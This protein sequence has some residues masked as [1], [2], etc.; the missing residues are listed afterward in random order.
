MYGHETDRDTFFHTSIGQTG[1]PNK[2][3][4]DD[5]ADGSVDEDELDGLDND[6]DWI[7][8]VDDL[9]GDGLTDTMETG[10]LGSYDPVTN[11]DPA[12]D[13]FDPSTRDLCRT[14]H[15]LKDSREVYA[16]NN[17]RPDIGEPH[18]DEDYG[19]LSESDVYIA[20]N[21]TVRT[22]LITDHIPLGIKVWQKSYTWRSLIKQP[23]MPFEYQIVNVG[24]RYLDSV[25]VGFFADPLVGPSTASGL[26]SNKYAGYLPELR[27]AFAQNA[28][29]RPSTP[30]GVVVL[31]TP[32]PLDSLRYTFQWSDFSEN[33]GTD[34][35]HY[36]YMSSGVIKPD[37]PRSQPGDVQFLLSFGP[38]RTIAPGET[39]RITVAL[40]SGESIDEGVNTLKQNAARAL[41][42]HYR[43]YQLPV[44]PPSPPL[45][46]SQGNNRVELS[47]DWRPG[48][49]RPD[50]LAAWDDSNKFVDQLPD[51][52]WRRRNPPAGHSRGG[53]IF[54]GFRLWRAESPDY[55]PKAFAL[56]QEYDVA[57]DLPFEFST[58]LTYNFTDSNLV[59]GRKYW[60]AVTSFSV[61]GASVLEIPDPDGG[62]PH[63]DTLITDPVESDFSENARLVQLPFDPSRH[64][65][66]VRVVPNPYRT[67]K[68]YT[69]E[70]GGWEGIGRLWTENRRVIWF[71]HLPTRCTI[72]IFSL[73]GD[74]VETIRHDD[75][76]R[77]TADRPPG[78]EE[79]N[80]LSGSGRAIASGIYLFAVE[81]EFGRQ[82]GKFVIIR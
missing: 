30:I 6:G 36:R 44:V 69:F 76:E 35:A 57:D 63:L 11:P 18:V 82:I 43:D 72:R 47:W 42:L 41:E 80:L 51:T 24:R 21:D 19:A 4:F 20:Y 62:P 73:G 79:W 2:R 38:F 59:R 34:A 5:D 15:P 10:C 16:Q 77:T 55:N 78:Q 70:T 56:M 48:D 3:R 60:Y 52:H 54:E 67:D 71:V 45:R 75:N 50:P 61:P 33:P 9:G 8:S 65:G 58:G 40:V 66:E 68:D 14:G 26:T 17:G 39:L 1:F 29:N 12:S 27:T 49:R 37:Q 22:G 7:A 32:R 31:R 46:V 23:I 81:S 25:F 74:L 28:V 64:L 13:N 53:R